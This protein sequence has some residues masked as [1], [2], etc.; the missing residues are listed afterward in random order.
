MG[1]NGDAMP[2]NRIFATRRDTGPRRGR[3]VIALAATGA[4]LVAVGFWLGLATGRR[5]PSGAA[6]GLPDLGPAPA[7]ALTNQLGQPVR[8]ARFVG[9]VQVVTFLFPYCTTYCPLIAA[10][11]IGFERLLERAG[12]AD[13]VELVAFNVDPAGTGP[14]QMRKFLKQYGWDPKDPHW[15]YL[16]GAPDAVRKAVTGGFHIAYQKVSDSDETSGPG[17]L[18]PQPEVRNDLATA[19][20]PGYDIS[21][22]DGLIVVGPGGHIRKIYDEADVVSN[23][24]L[25]RTVSS[26]LP[27]PPA[28]SGG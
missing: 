2:R 21:H 11:L 12:V 6:A 18:S 17:D 5:A 24:A 9:K 25:W 26:F 23:D 10:H 28:T 3:R 20:Q 7:Y 27:S 22:N 16:T 1:A 4:A 15:Q 13:Q 8:S 14:S 19:A